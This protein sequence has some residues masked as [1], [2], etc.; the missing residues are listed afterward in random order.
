MWARKSNDNGASWLPDDMFSDVLSP[1]PGLPDP[2]IVSTY[3]GDYD[4]A[5]AV[6][7]KH[8]ASWVDGRVAINNTSQQDAFFDK[9]SSLGGTPTPTPTPRPIPTPRSRPTPAPR[10]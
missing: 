5:S 2:D 1:L 9:D 4:Y 8:V 6:A 3:A 10:S 7:T